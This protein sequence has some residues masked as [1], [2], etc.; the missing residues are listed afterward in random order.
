MRTDATGFSL[1]EVL[2]ALAVLALAMTAL[3]RT[4]AIQGSN[5]NA[6]R[7]RIEAQWVAANVIAKTRISGTAIAEGSSD[8]DATMGRTRW[9]WRMAVAP[10][11]TPGVLRLDVRVGARGEREILLQGFVEA[12]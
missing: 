9:H 3:V 4:L 7:H 12:R 2:V 1:L 5:L 10:T 6:A 8:G 11:A